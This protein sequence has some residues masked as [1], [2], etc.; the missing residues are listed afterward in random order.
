MQF[1]FEHPFF[2]CPK[3]GR[4]E[5]NLSTPVLFKTKYIGVPQYSELQ[6][7]WI[8]KTIDCAVTYFLEVGPYVV[9][10]AVT[11]TNLR[12]VNEKMEHFGIVHLIQIWWNAL[13][14][15]YIHV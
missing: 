9:L 6:F 2:A 3:V 5:R 4:L 14:F 12:K 11:A 8:W 10:G 13:N 1:G 15:F 7:L